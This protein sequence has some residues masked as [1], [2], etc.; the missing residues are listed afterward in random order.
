MAARKS[1]A[2]KKKQRNTILIVGLLGI[3]GYVAWKQ[4]LF[5]GGLTAGPGGVTATTMGPQEKFN[6]D[7]KQ[8][9]EHP[10]VKPHLDWY[11]ANT[12]R[13]SSFDD[14]LAKAWKDSQQQGRAIWNSYSKK[15]SWRPTEVVPFYNDANQA[16]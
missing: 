8:N 2:A 5:G 10:A 1:K 14:F 9:P 11:N 7:A 3:G 12:A 16:V 15:Q 4:G 13:Y 6:Y